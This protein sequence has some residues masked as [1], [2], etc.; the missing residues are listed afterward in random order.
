MVMPMVVVVGIVVAAVEALLPL[1]P[2][3]VVVGIVVEA[4][5]PLLLQAV[6]MLPHRVAI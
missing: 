6:E 3:A 2:Q 4:L 1:L 5:L